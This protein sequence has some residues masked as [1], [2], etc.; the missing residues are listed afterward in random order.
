M[1][2]LLYKVDEKDR[3]LGKISRDEA[4]SKDILHRSAIVFLMD[5]DGRIF[6]QQRANTKK[7]FPDCLEASSTFHVEYGETYEGAAKREIKEELGLGLNAKLI[8]KFVHHDP[9]EH[10]VVD[11]LIAHYDGVSKIVLDP[12]ESSSGGFYTIDSVDRM[13]IK[14]RT[15]P[16]LCQGWKLLKDYLTK[17]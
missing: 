12:S 2:E 4:H 14:V 5:P 6:L 16:W 17:T 11:V 15:T 13:I 9:P 7:I 1:V 8:G 10:Q 3:V